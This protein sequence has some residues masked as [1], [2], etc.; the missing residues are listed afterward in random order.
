MLALAQKAKFYYFNIAI[1]LLAMT[2][3]LFQ[4]IFS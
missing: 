4:I 1:G 2:P 3:L